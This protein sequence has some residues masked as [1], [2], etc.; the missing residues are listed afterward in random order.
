V[1]NFSDEERA[2][3]I[4]EVP[5]PE[6]QLAKWRREHAEQEVRF[7]KERA[8]RAG[9]KQ[10]DGSAWNAWCDQRI[11]AALARFR[12]RGR[13]LLTEIIAEIRAEATDDLERAT[14]SLT[15]ELADLKATLAELRLVL[16]GERAS[17]V[18]L[19]NPLQHRPN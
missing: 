15:A 4:A 13:E 1:S 19:T 6:D 18:K 7:A 16:C 8:E 12:D 5:P 2:R 17:L 11:E 14:R 3:M 9:A 10:R